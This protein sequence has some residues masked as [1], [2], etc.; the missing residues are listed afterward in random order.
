VG[1]FTTEGKEPY[2]D[3]HLDRQKL[4]QIGDETA[5]GYVY[6]TEYIEE[7]VGFYTRYLANLSILKHHREQADRNLDGYIFELAFR[8]GIY[9]AT[10]K[11]EDEISECA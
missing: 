11:R 6:T 10:N 3:L 5:Q 4:V 2:P 9:D 8:D 7:R 1:E